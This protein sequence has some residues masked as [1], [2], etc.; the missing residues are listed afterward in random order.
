VAE[1]ND[2]LERKVLAKVAHYVDVPA[3]TVTL[4]SRLWHDLRLSGDDF[5][6][7]IEELH[8]ALGVTL[9][10]DLR[11]YCPPEVDWGWPW[12]FDGR[13]K[14]FREV[15]VSDLVRSARTKEKVG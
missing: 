11:D 15:F 3:E 4:D 1:Q 6:E 12:P 9:A 10:G 14:N 5:A 13:Y 8:L 7:L 2:E